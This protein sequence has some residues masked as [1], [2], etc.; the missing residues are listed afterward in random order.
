MLTTDQLARFLKQFSPYVHKAEANKGAFANGYDY[1]ASF[2]NV[3]RLMEMIAW[4]FHLS[5]YEIFLHEPSWSSRSGW[6]SFSLRPEIEE[7]IVQ[8]LEG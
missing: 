1:R 4:H 8:E 5:P 6:I 7:R 2:E 3:E